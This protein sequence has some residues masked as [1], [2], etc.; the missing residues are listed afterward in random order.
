[1]YTRECDDSLYE[2]RELWRV[3]P[4]SKAF[5]QVVREEREKQGMS[6]ER[7]GELAGVYR[8]YMSR[9]ELGQV[10]LGFDVAQKL[11]TGLG[12]PLSVLVARAEERSNSPYV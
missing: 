8:T 11:A 1:V 10:R 6:Q 3:Q 2:S 7:L 9:V 4:L 12:M 5:G